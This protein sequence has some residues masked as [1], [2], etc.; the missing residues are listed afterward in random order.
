MVQAPQHGIRHAA[1][2]PAGKPAGN[3]YHN[4]RRVPHIGIDPP[5]FIKKGTILP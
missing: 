3:G 4:F 5:Q 1:L 2:R